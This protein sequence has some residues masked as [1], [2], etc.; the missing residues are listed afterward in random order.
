MG[1]NDFYQGNVV[2]NC[3]VAFSGGDAIGTENG[4]LTSRLFLILPVEVIEVA[5]PDNLSFG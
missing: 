4:E 2:T 3:T 5:R 1:T